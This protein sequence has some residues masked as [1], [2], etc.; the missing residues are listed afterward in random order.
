MTT[1][2][3]LTTPP[4]A[5]G[6]LYILP[7][8]YLFKRIEEGREVVKALSSEQIALAFREVQ[9]DSGWINR[10]IL[11][12]REA[13]E[14]SIVLSYQSA[15]VR[16]ISIQDKTGDVSEIRLPLPTLVLL[17]V[18]D[19]FYI[20][21]AKNRVV[22]SETKLSIAPL[23][24]IGGNLNGKICFGRN[25]TPSANI[26]ETDAIWNLFWNTP[27]NGDGSN[28]KCKSEPKDVRKLLFNLS[29]KKAKRFPASELIESD[30][31]VEDLWMR[32]VEKKHSYNF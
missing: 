4:D 18:G 14:G 31:T 7:G 27:F 19:E 3:I 1:K 8:Q 29:E 24:N 16:S 23:P 21:A 25:E 22:T 2:H 11:R 15:G 28:G 10:R 13:P 5:L 30:T 9:T 20:W 12:F 6:A 32:V 26:D 17:G